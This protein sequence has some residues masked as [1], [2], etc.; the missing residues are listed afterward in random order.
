CEQALR[1][2]KT[3]IL[4]PEGTR[5]E[6]GVLAPLKSGVWHLS[7]R[8]PEVPIIPVGLRGTE[9]V[10]AKGN[11]IPLPL[12]IDVNIGDALST[13][14]EKKTFMDDLEQRLTALLQP[15]QGNH[16]HD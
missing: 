1:E 16:P 15:S 11:R 12:F 13:H 6:P 2:G 3:L 14:P 10:M 5:G 9:R 4:F 7:Q 8:M